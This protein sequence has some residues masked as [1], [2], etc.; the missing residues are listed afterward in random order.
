MLFYPV[1]NTVKCEDY[2]TGVSTQVH[3]DPDGDIWAPLEANTTLYDHFWFWSPEKMMKRK[4]PDQLMECY[5]KSVGYGSVFLLNSTPDTTGLIPDEDRKLY[6]AFGEEIDRRF[7][8]PVAALL[9]AKGDEIFLDL[10][11][12]ARINHLITME[13]YRWGQRIRA[14][15]FEGYRNGKWIKLCEGQSVG[16][17]KIDYF[18][19]ID[20]SKVRLTIDKAVGEPLI[21]SLSAHYVKDFIAPPKR[22]ISVWSEWQNLMEYRINKGEVLKIKIDLSGKIKLPGQYSLQAVPENPRSQIS[23]GEIE[24]YYNG[25]PALNKFVSSEGN[26]IHINRTAQVTGESCITLIFSVE[27]TEMGKGIIYFRPGLIY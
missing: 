25:Y 1:W 9:D 7:G 23:L 27:S 12:Q 11:E 15:T 18:P 21:R 2:I 26:T 6:K 3:D 17:K 19:M 14:Y 24:L 13:D 4:S 20:V 22:S 8:S 16:R 10:P 5:Y